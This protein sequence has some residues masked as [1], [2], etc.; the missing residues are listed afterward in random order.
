MSEI[1]PVTQVSPVLFGVVKLVWLDGYEAVVDLR[2]VIAEGDLFEF[3]R[4]SPQRFNAVQLE[5]HGHYI[6][7]NDD[8]G[9][10]IEFGADSLRRRAIRQA[11]ILRLA[12]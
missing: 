1:I 7:W 4:A 11:E 3:L 8:S 5:T 12:S 10:E 9:D 2:P 6:F